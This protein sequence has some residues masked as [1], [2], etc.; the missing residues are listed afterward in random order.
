MSGTFQE[1]KREQTSFV[2]PFERCA[3][4][5]LARRMPAWVNSDHLT[6]VGFVAFVGAGIGYALTT[7]GP[8]WL[9][10]VNACLFLNWFGDSLDGTLARYRN[11]LRPRYGFYVDHVTDT[12][13]S[14]ILVLGL[15]ASPYMSAGVALALLI[16]F[17]ML[18]INSYLATHALGTFKLSFWKFSPTELRLLLAIGNL[19]LLIN[20]TATLGGIRFLLYDVGGVIAVVGMIGMFIASA[21][22]NTVRLYRMEPRQGGRV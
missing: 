19:V 6:V 17:F 16:A 3:L 18:S 8:G 9:H 20:P 11:H 12:A 1:S 7:V 4:Q 22:S 10:A 5:W 13:G 14:L 2:A 15:A 21:V